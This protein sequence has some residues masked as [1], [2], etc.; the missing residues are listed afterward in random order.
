MEVTH[1][2][3]HV[4]WARAD[5]L[6]VSLHVAVAHTLCLGADPREHSVDVRQEASL[7]VAVLAVGRVWR[8][9]KWSYPTAKLPCMGIDGSHLTDKLILGVGVKNASSLSSRSPSIAPFRSW[10]AIS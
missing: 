6:E 9:R 3:F 8:Q 10:C 4:Q 1:S 5:S 2:V 7:H